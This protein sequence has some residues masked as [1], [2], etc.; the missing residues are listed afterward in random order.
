MGDVQNLSDDIKSMQKDREVSRVAVGKHVPAYEVVP[1]CRTREPCRV[2][3]DLI[4]TLF[5]DKVALS[6]SFVCYFQHALVPIDH[7]LAIPNK[8]I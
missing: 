4:P 8:A 6:I 1:Y 5:L 3:R 7:F 2:D